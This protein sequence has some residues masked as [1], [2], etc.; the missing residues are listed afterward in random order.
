MERPSTFRETCLETCF[1]APSQ[2]VTAALAYRA[3]NNW[4]QI[5]T[6]ECIFVFCRLRHSEYFDTE[7]M[8]QQRTTP[9]LPSPPFQRW[10]N[11]AFS[12]TFAFGA[13]S[14]LIW[15]VKKGFHF[16]SILSKI[17]GWLCKLTNT[18]WNRAD[19][20]QSSIVHAPFY[21]YRSG[22]WSTPAATV[23]EIK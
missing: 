6:E 13:N 8:L 11:G 18:F 10:E 3:S 7:N 15:G 14:L 1:T 9:P 12:V 20:T 23:A 17:V 19:D 21:D 16:L 4:V 22:K 2:R 5:L